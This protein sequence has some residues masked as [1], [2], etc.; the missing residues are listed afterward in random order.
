VKTIRAQQRAIEIARATKGVKSVVDRVKVK[1]KTWPASQIRK[2]VEQA[3]LLDP[4]TESFEIGVDV[5]AGKVTLTGEV[6]SW[7][8]KWLAGDVARGVR[9]VAEVDNNVQVEAMEERSDEEIA[10]DIEA[11][12]RNDVRVDD[13]LMTVKVED[14]KVSLSGTVG[15]AAEK[16]RARTDAWVAGVEDVDAEG[17]EVKWWARDKMRRKEPATP[18]DDMIEKAVESAFLYDP[19]VNS[20]NPEVSVEDGVVTLTG[21]VGDLKAKFAARRDAANTV[22]VVRVRNLLRVRPEPVLSDKEITD[23]VRAA[24]KRDPLIESDDIS[25]A[26][27]NGK[28]YLSG[29]VTSEFHK[30]HVQDMVVRVGGV[31]AVSNNIVI[32][33]P[34][35]PMSDVELEADI[36]SR[37]FWNPRVDGSQVQVEVENGVVTL[38]G[39]VSSLTERREAS[40]AAWES[41]ASAVY[42]R[43][44]VER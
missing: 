15:S 1:P 12:L 37:L 39:E 4:A 13:V 32:E 17:L 38:T 10:R 9:G 8:E 6:E 11:R 3:L 14:G 40:T 22:G 35:A 41:G 20:F 21:V 31:E 19:R 27:L 23:K 29:T 33:R 34:S 26:V 44:D 24:V 16:E 30:W 36:V 7:Q 43:L 5:T 42:N 28:V 25:F 2:D 18:S